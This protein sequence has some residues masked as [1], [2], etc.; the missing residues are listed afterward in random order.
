MICDAGFRVRRLTLEGPYT[1]GTQG[2]FKVLTL[3]SGRAAV[4]WR[5]QGEEEPLVVESPDSVLV[6]A[7]IEE[8]FLSPVGSVTILV[9]DAGSGG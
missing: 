7:C 2:S 9:S 3:L 4:G 8:V 5:S 6:P 1:V